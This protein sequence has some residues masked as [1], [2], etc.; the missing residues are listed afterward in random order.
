VVSMPS[1]S[2]GVGGDFGK[3][4][5]SVFIPTREGFNNVLARS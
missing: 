2:L 3:S 4:K 5:M 1:S